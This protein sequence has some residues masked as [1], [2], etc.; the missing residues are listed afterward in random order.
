[1]PIFKPRGWAALSRALSIRTTLRMR[2]LFFNFRLLQVQSGLAK[3]DAC[4]S[5][6]LPCEPGGSVWNAD[7]DGFTCGARI[8]WLESNDGGGKSLSD[9]KNQV[10]T[11]YAVPYRCCS[12]QR[13]R[14]CACASA[15][16]R[17][18]DSRPKARPGA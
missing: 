4:G 12:R 1:V 7:A 2:V 17:A 9:A 14:S 10:A 8:E 18:C 16:Q 11:E 15:F 13:Y 5:M 6:P 3:L